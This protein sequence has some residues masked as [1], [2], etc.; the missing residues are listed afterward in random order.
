M[1]HKLHQLY[2]GVES[3]LRR[4]RESIF[5]PGVNQQIKDFVQQCDSCQ[6]F[7]PQQRKETLIP[8]HI[9]DKPLAKVGADLFLFQSNEFLI[10]V[11]YHS[12]Y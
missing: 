4:A 6:T 9:V 1:L 7:G 3:C 8:H 5:W 10:T 2:I 11:D 12:N